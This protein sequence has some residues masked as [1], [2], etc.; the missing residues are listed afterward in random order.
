L[1]IDILFNHGKYIASGATMSDDGNYRY[2]L[3]RR[4]AGG[5]EP[6]LWVCLNPS[7]AHSRVDDA[8]VRKLIAL[9]KRWQYNAL[10]VV[11]LFAWRATDPKELKKAVDPIGLDYN[12][13]SIAEQLKRHK[14]VV[15]AWGAHGS[16]HDRGAKV[17]ELIR[18][19]RPSGA[20]VYTLGLTKNG[21]PKHPLYLRNDVARAHF[22][23]EKSQRL[24]TFSEL[25]GP[26][27]CEHEGCGVLTFHCL[28]SA[29]EV[30]DGAANLPP[31]E[32]VRRKDIG[33]MLCPEHLKKHA[34]FVCRSLASAQ[35]LAT[36][37]S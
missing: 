28:L 33:K 29:E 7:T 20:R 16:L 4:W 22:L 9:S 36:A 12:D 11:N 6:L 19:C 17:L 25:Y 30:A 15:L 26:F 3:E 27:P 1:I 21:Q 37:N 32:L 13:V 2:T 34:P 8:T 5:G 10:T 31:V 23:D 35:A 14:E 24:Y 18:S